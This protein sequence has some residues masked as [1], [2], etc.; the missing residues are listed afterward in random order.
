[1]II[2]ITAMLFRRILNHGMERN[3]E[4]HGT[5]QNIKITERNDR[6]TAITFDNHQETDPKYYITT[7]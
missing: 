2:T 5:E 4:N 1:M 6:P 7:P 3:A